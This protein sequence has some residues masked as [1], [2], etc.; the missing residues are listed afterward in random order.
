M[1]S[2]PLRWLAVFVAVVGVTWLLFARLPGGFLPE[3]DQ[4]YFVINYDAPPAATMAQTEAAV[5]AVETE[6]AKLPQSQEIFSVIGFNFF[7][8]G[9]TA[10]LSWA[11]LKPFDE[12]KGKDLSVDSAIGA[13]FGAAANVPGANI[14]AINPPAI[15]SL[16]NATG[17]T[18]PVT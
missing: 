16:G 17:F 13:V 18:K 1:L 8:Q 12:R 4:G 6:F 11:M 10:G 15:D 9:Q 2:R 5:K 3:E 14:F 7:G